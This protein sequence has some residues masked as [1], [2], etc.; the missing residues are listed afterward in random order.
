M[1]TL[2]RERVGAIIVWFFIAAF[3]GLIILEWGASYSDTAKSSSD[4]IGVINGREIAHRQ[5]QQAVR[6]AAQQQAQSSQSNDDGQIVRQ[7]WDS[8]VSE[9]LVAQEVKRLGIVVT[10]KELDYYTR[11][12]PPQGVRS[13]ELFQNEA[14][15][16]DPAKYNQFL[17]DPATFDDPNFKNFVLQIESLLHNQVLNF[18]LQRLIMETVQT[19]PL[20]VRQRYIDQN[21]KVVVEYLFA[22]SSAL[23]DSEVTANQ[24]DLEAYYQDN[25]DTFK[26]EEQVRLSYVY[27]PTVPTAA[28]SQ[29]V[30]KEIDGLREEVLA[31]AAF[32]DLAEAVSQDQGSA[33]N[34][35][36]LGAFGRDR[37]VKPFADAVFALE[38]G[39]LSEPVQTV[40][41]WHLIKV[42][43]KLEEDGE[44]KVKARHILLK[45]EPSRTTE[46]DSRK[47]AESLREAALT[48]GLQAAAQAAGVQAVDAGYLEKNTPIQILGQNTS[49]VVNSFFTRPNGSISQVGA[50]ENGYWV[51]QLEDRRAAGVASLE[52]ERGTIDR[53]ARQRKKAERAA[54]KLAD[55]RQQIIAGKSMA[56]VGLE[57]RRTEPFARTD[58]VPGIG[59]ANAFVGAAFKLEKG[60]VSEPV[61]MPRGA[62]LL[63]LL[64]KTEIDE[65]LFEEQRQ[66]LQVQLEQES[67]NAAVQTWFAQLYQEAEIEDNRHSFYSF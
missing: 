3:V 1:M 13:M 66:E 30:R 9:V 6:N 58:F 46:E 59:R 51:A 37:M 38:V 57:L 55:L 18:K 60:R 49:W 31:G 53:Q 16:F 43:E 63:N 5:F 14:G 56:E 36:D 27:M 20:E 65:G 61:L 2:I 39:G 64:E 62:Y 10:D 28:D 4:S 47:R 40:F 25:L 44:E 19:S 33:V 29:A 41:G 32:A 23:A 52:E 50:N 35:G 21:E 24:A 45:Y 11:T 8:I 34:G 42:E 7:V 15:E 54:E 22:P 26:H 12:Q 17:S 67:R 48:Q